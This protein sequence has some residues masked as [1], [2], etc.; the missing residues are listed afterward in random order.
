MTNPPPRPA[1]RKAPDATISPAVALVSPAAPEWVPPPS[2]GAK[3]S[4]GTKSKGITLGPVPAAQKSVTF[5]ITIPKRL[6][7][8]LDQRAEEFG[9]SRDEVLTTLLE[10]WLEG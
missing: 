1:L 8:Q 9:R 7:K 5:E 10:A 3:G 2:K 4:K 6:R